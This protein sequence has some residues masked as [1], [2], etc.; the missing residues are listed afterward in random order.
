[1][2]GNTVLIERASDPEICP[3][4]TLKAYIN[5][6]ATARPRAD[7]Q[8]VFITLKKALKM[9]I[10]ISHC[11]NLVTGTQELWPTAR[12]ELLPAISVLQELGR[13]L[14]GSGSNSR[15]APSPLEEV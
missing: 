3:I 4:V 10:T 2:S 6:T 1:M 9:L 7:D 5:A 15:P 14:T 12:P 8:P 13:Q 11:S